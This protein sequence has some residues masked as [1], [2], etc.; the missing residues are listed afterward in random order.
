MTI[1][2]EGSKGTL[3]ADDM[4]LIIYVVIRKSKPKKVVFLFCKGHSFETINFDTSCI[5]RIYYA[6]CLY[7]FQRRKQNFSYL[8]IFLYFILRKKFEFL[9]MMVKNAELC[10]QFILKVLYCWSINDAF[11]IRSLNKI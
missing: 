1:V 8:F 4:H 11:E 5:K 9:L 6:N 2:I 3:A 10:I 7:R